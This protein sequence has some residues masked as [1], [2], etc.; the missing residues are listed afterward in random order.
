MYGFK[1]FRLFNYSFHKTA[2]QYFK[3]NTLLNLKKKIH[4]NK[5]IHKYNLYHKK[6]LYIFC[7]FILCNFI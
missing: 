6:N 1:R 3:K 5:K 4:P 7:N 2:T